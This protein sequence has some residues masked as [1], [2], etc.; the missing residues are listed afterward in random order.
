MAEDKKK[1]K[2]ERRPQAQK[3]VIQSEKRRFRNRTQK[4]E[5]RSA[6]RRFEDCIVKGEAPVIKEALSQVYCL[7]D[8][9]VKN[10]VWKINKGSRTKSRLT[11]KAASKA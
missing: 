3:R 9:A 1:E 6:I 7:V 10:G 2:K 8:K 5:I 11:A 4:S